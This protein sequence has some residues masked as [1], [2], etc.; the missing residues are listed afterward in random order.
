MKFV[1]SPLTSIA[2]C[3]SNTGLPISAA[4]PPASRPLH[5]LPR[6]EP[7]E[8]VTRV[9]AAGDVPAA[10]AGAQEGVAIH[11]RYASNIRF[12]PIVRKFSAR[13]HEQLELADAALTSGDMEALARFGHWLA[14]TAGTVGYDAF[15]LPARE[16]QALAKRGDAQAAATALVQ[17]TKMASLLV[18][19]EAL[20]AS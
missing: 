18:V 2:R 7:A 17:L 12:S 11:S 14:G 1:R 6:C 3:S 19:P 16:L 5:G 10:L 8:T 9:G 4:S 15:T 13:L 20:A